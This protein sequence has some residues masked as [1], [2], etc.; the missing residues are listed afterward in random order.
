MPYATING[1]RIHYFDTHDAQPDR[2]NSSPPIFMIHGLGSSQN[3][4]MSVISELNDYRCVALDSY[5][6][7]RSK[8]NGEDLTL[9]GLGED[10]V[11][12]MDQLNVPKAVVA[13]H[14]M[15][16][17]MAL[18]IAASHP[19]RIAGVVGIGPVSPKHVKPEMFTT[20]INTV[21]KGEPTSQ[22]HRTSLPVPANGHQTAWSPLPTPSRNLRR[23]RRAPLCSDRSS[24][25]SFSTRIPNHTRLI[26][27]SSATCVSRI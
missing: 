4:Y 6:A 22:E 23:T 24:E 16:G 3:F 17:P 18:T 25:S 10:I 2:G 19:D 8:S 27:T 1:H 13:G 21:L 9:E 12:L 7:A 15:G 11:A 20:R 5:G 14:S 26:A